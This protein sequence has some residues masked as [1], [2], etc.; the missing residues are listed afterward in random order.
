MRLLNFILILITIFS[1]II[2]S[3]SKVEELGKKEARNEVKRLNSLLDSCQKTET[4]LKLE[5]D[6]LK[7]KLIININELIENKK[8]YDEFKLITNK[9]NKD[10]EQLIKLLNYKTI[11]NL[12]EFLDLRKYYPL[13]SSEIKRDLYNH[14]FILKYVDVIKRQLNNVD[15]AKDFEIKNYIEYS[16]RKLYSD[17]NDN[18]F[19]FDLFC[20][21]NADSLFFSNDIYTP[22]SFA[23][24]NTKYH[25]LDY[26]L[27]VLDTVEIKDG[28]ILSFHM[29]PGG[30]TDYKLLIDLINKKKIASKIANIDNFKS[31]F[32]EIAG[33]NYWIRAFND[34]SFFINSDLIKGYSPSEKEYLI[35]FDLF[36]EFDSN[37]CSSFTILATAI[38]ENNYDELQAF[39]ILKIKSISTNICN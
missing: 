8:S 33:K 29:N 22:S 31:N 21:I 14:I 27:I 36:K 13:L 2:Y 30:S 5:N 37:A 7:I 25:E 38:L 18:T 39:K 3:Q 24:I 20:D 9:Y 12:D 1:N 10:R 23:L 4:K 28:N 15:I 34:D 19:L 6:S 16:F 35:E 11:L 17:F 32:S 26:R